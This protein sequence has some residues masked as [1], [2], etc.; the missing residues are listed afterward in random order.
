ML[1][2][3][4]LLGHP[5]DHLYCKID[6]L[7]LYFKKFIFFFTDL[8]KSTLVVPLVDTHDMSRDSPDALRLIGLRKEGVTTSY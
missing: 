4:L 3:L 8:K 7:F 6:W 1:F 5:L 2:F